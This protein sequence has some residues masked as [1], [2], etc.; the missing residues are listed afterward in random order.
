M[1]RRP[2]KLLRGWD[3]EKTSTSLVVTAL[4]C[5]VGWLLYHFYR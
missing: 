3:M 1:S 4:V 2:Q 5:S